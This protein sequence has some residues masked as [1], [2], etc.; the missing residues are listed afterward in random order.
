[1]R[2]SP[3][4]LERALKLAERQDSVIARPVHGAVAPRPIVVC[5]DRRSRWL[6]NHSLASLYLSPKGLRLDRPRPRGVGL[7]ASRGAH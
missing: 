5:L 3:M 4:A 1:M 2:L 6:S 7:S